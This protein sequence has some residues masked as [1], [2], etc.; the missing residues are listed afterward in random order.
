M[1]SSSKHV[2]EWILRTGKGSRDCLASGQTWH[3]N[4]GKERCLQTCKCLRVLDEACLRRCCQ[5]REA[6]SNFTSQYP[7]C[8]VLCFFTIFY[9]FYHFPSVITPNISHFLSTLRWLKANCCLTALIHRN[10]R[11]LS[12][13][14]YYYL[15][16]YL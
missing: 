11:L 1:C 7:L 2:V 9:V 8:G 13:F 15:N 14:C 12:L 3:V 4:E 6:I 5:S 10:C 16:A